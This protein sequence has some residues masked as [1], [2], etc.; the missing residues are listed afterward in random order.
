MDQRKKKWSSLVY[1]RSFSKN[2]PWNTKNRIF[3]K[4]YKIRKTKTGNVLGRSLRLS[5]KTF[6]GFW[7]IRWL[8]ITWRALWSSFWSSFGPKLYVFYSVFWNWTKTGPKCPP[9]YSE[10]GNQPKPTKIFLEKL[11]DLPKTFL[12]LLYWKTI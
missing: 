2:S 7:F 5:K 1:T 12:V 10:P 9:S 4:Y 3:K 11:K 6:G 8:R